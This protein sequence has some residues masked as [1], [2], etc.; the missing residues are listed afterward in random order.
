M[1][2]IGNVE[3]ENRIVFAPMAGISNLVYRNIIK[4]MGAGLVYTEMVSSM[5]IVYGSEKTIEL[6]TI[7]DYERPVSIQLFG[8]DT[9]AFVKAAKY[10]EQNFHPSIID[11]NMGCPV[12]KVAGKSGGGSALLKD[13]DKIY[14]IVSSITK[15]IS[16]PVTAKIRIGW[17]DKS[18]NA[19]EVAKTLERAG[20]SAIA[21][22]GRTRAQGY[23]GKANWDIIRKVKESVNIPVIGNGDITTIEEAKR[24]LEETKVDAVMIGRAALGNPW[25]IKECVEYVENGNIIPKPTY[26]GRLDMIKTHYNK[27]EELFGSKRAVLEIRSHA[28]WYLK[29]L[30]DNKEIKNKIVHIE[31]K[32]ELFDIIE[33]Y[34][35]RLE[36]EENE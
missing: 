19:I 4:S 28:L 7:N 18:I 24:M 16:T 29:G 8:S 5:G 10:V 34:K 11:I 21:V 22:H 17:D 27:L 23:T 13:V 1:W 12:P 3:I 20:A 6:L 36:S 33:E 35:K 25:L 30:K 14:E 31:S 9:D 32:Q 2:K 15:N 26:V